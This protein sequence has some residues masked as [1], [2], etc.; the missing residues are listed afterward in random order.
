[1]LVFI[2]F[3]ILKQTKKANLIDANS[4]LCVEKV[5]EMLFTFKFLSY[6]LTIHFL[7]SGTRK[8]WN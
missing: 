7:N 4:F 2:V 1:M 8:N 3:G 5:D 6:K